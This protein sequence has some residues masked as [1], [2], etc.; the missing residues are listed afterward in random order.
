MPESKSK[1]KTDSSAPASHQKEAPKFPSEII[2]LPSND[3]G[4][5]FLKII[6]LYKQAYNLYL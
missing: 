4:I 1:P 2:D 3:K 5:I 6:F